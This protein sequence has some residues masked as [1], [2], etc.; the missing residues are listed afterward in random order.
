MAQQ[1]F[2]TLAA[3]VGDI[4]HEDFGP[5]IN[6]CS[7]ETRNQIDT[8]IKQAQVQ[9]REWISKGIAKVGRVSVR[10]ASDP[11]PPSGHLCWHYRDDQGR[12]S[13]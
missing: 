4:I 10:S 7:L 5:A 6:V 8:L 12:P 11:L 13:L 1:V 2:I 9:V 3:G